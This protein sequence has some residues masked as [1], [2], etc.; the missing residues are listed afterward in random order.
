MTHEDAA[1]ILVNHPICGVRYNV[2]RRPLSGGIGT[3]RPHAAKSTKTK[4]TPAETE[5]EF[6][7]RLR[8]DYLAAD[9]GYWFF[10][11]RAEISAK[12]IQV[13]RE[14]CLDP[15][16]EALCLWYAITTKQDIGK[17]RWD[18]GVN[19]F[20]YRTP[21]GVYSALE[22]DGATEYDA[23]LETGSEAGL[24]RVETLFPEL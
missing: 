23:Y 1:K 7:E 4:F 5:E 8:R 21:F 9:P 15:M 17:T 11:V 6:Y 19:L 12:D 16:L 22:E 13:F 2:C 14:T 3:I 10:R 24:R 20:H 18:K